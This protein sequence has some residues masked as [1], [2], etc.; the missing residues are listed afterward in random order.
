MLKLKQAKKRGGEEM[1]A[2]VKGYIVGTDSFMSKKKGG[3]VY[4][5][6]IYDGRELT[7]IN[8]VPEHMYVD[9]GTHDLVEI[10][11][12]IYAG[13]RLYVVYDKKGDKA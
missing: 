7:R 5:I 9:A 12:I 8:D 1:R 4:T 3:E 2:T 10:P 13:E 6:D 11:V